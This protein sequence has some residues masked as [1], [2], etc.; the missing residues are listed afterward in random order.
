MTKTIDRAAEVIARANRARRERRPHADV[1]IVT[2]QAARDYA[3]ALAKAGL[4]APDLP[5]SNWL[6]DGHPRE[7]VTPNTLAVG[8][9]WD[10]ADALTLACRQSEL[11]QIAVIDCDGDVYVWGA[12]AEWWQTGWPSYGCAPYTIIRAGKKADQ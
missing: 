5:E 10:D 4:L 3:R 12:D 1:D 8:S 7:D 2:V 6:T 9:V 11:D